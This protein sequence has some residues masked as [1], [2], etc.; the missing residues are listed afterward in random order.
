MILSH[1]KGRS[2]ENF[3]IHFVGMWIPFLKINLSDFHETMSQL[4]YNFP[5][6]NMNKVESEK[7]TVHMD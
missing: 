1:K 5:G 3:Y 6:K 4:K 7:K 2:C